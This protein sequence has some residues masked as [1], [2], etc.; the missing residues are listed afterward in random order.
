MYLVSTASVNTWI[1]PVKVPVN[2]NIALCTWSSVDES[3]VLLVELFEVN[4]T[5]A[6]PATFTDW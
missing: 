2:S 4:V 3:S 5:L 6:E 1:S